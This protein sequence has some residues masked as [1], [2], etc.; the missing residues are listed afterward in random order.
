MDCFKILE[1]DFTTDKKEVKKAYARLLKKYHPEEN[2]IKFEEINK[3]Y[4]EACNISEYNFIEN[5]YDDIIKEDD[6]DNIFS[7][8]E[9][10]ESNIFDE[11]NFYNVTDIFE[12]NIIDITFLFESLMLYP[13]KIMFI[14]EFKYYIHNI[15]DFFSRWKFLFKSELLNEDDSKDRIR[16]IIRE[17]FTIV[18]RT[19]Q[20]EIWDL[21]LLEN[22]KVY[23]FDKNS[24]KVEVLNYNFM[25][26][27]S[28]KLISDEIEKIKMR[29]KSVKTIEGWIYKFKEL[30]QKK[31]KIDEYEELFNEIEQD[32]IIE[33]KESISQILK[34]LIMFNVES[35]TYDL[36]YRLRR[37]FAWNRS[38]KNEF[39][40]LEKELKSKL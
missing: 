15:Q 26:K 5:S 34:D 29:Q 23:L 36:I 20:K 35:M 4:I 30:Y 11:Y 32:R 3:A 13:K 7:E 27:K 6:E 40:C 39:Y 37:L 18:D 22:E 38:E 33:K 2:P 21:L 16:M 10:F 17:Y 12:E 24:I 19:V 31:S 14:G 28:R 1:I 9:G 25:E 8:I